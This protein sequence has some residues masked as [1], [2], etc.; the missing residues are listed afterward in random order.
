MQY[1]ID[2]QGI[3]Y[4]IEDQIADETDR[5]LDRRRAQAAEPNLPEISLTEA[6]KTCQD[7]SAQIAALDSDCE[8]ERIGVKP[9]GM[10][11]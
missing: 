1:M 7:I 11:E 2:E 5:L 8:C 6:I 10:C 3:H 9:C 4:M